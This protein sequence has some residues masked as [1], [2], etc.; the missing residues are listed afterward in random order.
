SVKTMAEWMK[1]GGFSTLGI[2]T[3]SHLVKELGFTRG[4]DDYCYEHLAGADWVTARAVERLAGLKRPFFL[5]MHFMDAHSPANPPDA[6]REFFGPL[7]ALS[8]EEQAA[9]PKVFPAL[10]AIQSGEGRETLRILYD[11]ECRFMD[12]ELGKFLTRLETEAPG[13]LVIVL[14]DHGEEFWDH[15]T[16]GHGNTLFQEQ[17]A[18]PFFLHGPGIVPNEVADPVSTIHL[19]PMLAAYLGR[20]PE[21]AW[22]GRNLLGVPAPDAPVFASTYGFTPSKHS[23]VEMVR[24]GPAKFFFKP[25]MEMD[26]LFDLTADPGEK[27]DLASGQPETVA[28]MRALLTG[29]LKDNYARRPGKR[30]AVE[31]PPELREQQ[32][33]I[34]YGANDEGK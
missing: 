4:F 19:L 30:N 27:A 15:G 6:Y 2:Q 34:G 29:Q 26:S 32:I 13:T 10:L 5:Y 8:P 22:Q 3:N 16:V 33:K 14:A 9:I 23:H 24:T 11:A 21:A 25:S 18:V 12:D 7:P 28:R 20:S 31:L 1:E 17:I